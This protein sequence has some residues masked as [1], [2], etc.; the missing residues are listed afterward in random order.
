M[1][2][3]EFNTGK[4]QPPPPLYTLLCEAV[5]CTSVT[6]MRGLSGEENAAGDEFIVTGASL[7]S[8]RSRARYFSCIAHEDTFALQASIA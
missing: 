5:Q 8:R 4:D 2:A 7:Y 1:E 6:E 3:F